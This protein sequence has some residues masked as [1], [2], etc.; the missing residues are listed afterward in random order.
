MKQNVFAVYDSKAEMFNQPM[1]FKAVPEALRAFEDECNRPES[2]LAKHPDDYTLF[3]IGEYDVETGL[4]TPLTTPNSY[5]LAR[6]YQK[7]KQ[8]NVVKPGED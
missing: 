1:F 5:G 4:L 3:Q 8:Q 7:F 6:E 2:A